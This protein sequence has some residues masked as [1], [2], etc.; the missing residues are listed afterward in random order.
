[1]KT[2]MT[3]RNS[4]ESQC[5]YPA[6][7][8]CR[9]QPL[10]QRYEM[11]LGSSHCSHSLICVIRLQSTFSVG[12]V[13]LKPASFSF[14]PKSTPVAQSPKLDSFSSLFPTASLSTYRAPTESVGSQAAPSIDA[15]KIPSHAG[16]GSY[17]S[18]PTKGFGSVSGSGFGSAPA[19]AAPVSPAEPSATSVEKSNVNESRTEAE[20]PEQVTAHQQDSGDQDDD[21]QQ[22]TRR[23]KRQHKPQPDADDDD[24]DGGDDYDDEDDEDGGP[25]EEDDDEDYEDDGGQDSDDDDNGED[26]DEDDEDDE[27]ASAPTEE[28]DEESSDDDGK[29]DYRE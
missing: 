11:T 15:S 19:T 27:D 6:C 24:D 1:M 13:N 3:M 9:T 18:A 8:H 22:P 20:Q 5:R 2:M 10:N 16:F 28:D 14:T 4:E 25:D 17:S 26:A 29:Q 7:T 23:A 12:E 21:Q